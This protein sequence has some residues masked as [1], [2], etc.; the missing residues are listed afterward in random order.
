MTRSHMHFC[1]HCLLSLAE[2]TYTAHTYTYWS[3]VF[4][5]QDCWQWQ[6][7][8][9]IHRGAYSQTHVLKLLLCL[10]MEYG[11]RVQAVPRHWQPIQPLL[12]NVPNYIIQCLI[13]YYIIKIIKFQLIMNLC[14]RLLAQPLSVYS[15]HSMYES[16]E[17]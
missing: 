16:N 11:T 9:N 4:P 14:T 7:P 2:E 8:R 10:T 13:K 1:F 3:K 17:S 15:C 12:M 6:W 5:H